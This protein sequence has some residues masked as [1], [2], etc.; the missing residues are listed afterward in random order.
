[1]PTASTPPPTARA[2]RSH[3][4]RGE[5]RL[6]TRDQ[7]VR[8]GIEA[9]LER[10]WAASGVDAVLRSVGV[11][12]GSFYHYFPSKDAFGH[13]VIDAYQAY[14]LR[15]L[16]RCF[17]GGAS[18]AAQFDAFLRESLDGM[19]RH[20]WRR[21]CLIGALGQELGGLHEGFRER[22]LA[23]LTEWE[24]VLDT[25]LRG[26][27]ARGEIALQLDT[28]RAARGFWAAWEGAVLRARLGRDGAPLVAAVTDFLQLIE[29]PQPH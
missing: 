16:A 24:D 4:E 6:G 13:A 12:K 7:L 10:G 9:A 21:G 3:A 25:A 20:G 8:A 11:P 28:R 18:L 26:A 29:H 2:R 27:Q 14:F 5:Q 1:M 22:L 15:R 23:S 17:G 19:A